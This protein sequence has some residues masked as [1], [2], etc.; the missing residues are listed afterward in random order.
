MAGNSVE[1]MQA[2][3]SQLSQIGLQ[4]C[5]K[6]IIE[7]SKYLIADD[8]VNFAL[9]PLGV[10]NNGILTLIIAGNGSY[11]NR[12]ASWTLF[13]SP[14]T[15]SGTYEQIH[16]WSMSCEEAKKIYFSSFGPQKQLTLG[17]SQSE[18]NPTT[19]VY[20]SS[21]GLDSCTTVKK[22]LLP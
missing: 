13:A 8:K 22:E 18:L 19:H 11:G 12:L 17:I 14:N 3:D 21:N 1:A 16:H 20:F 10:V 15:C 2:L 5:R 4:V 7:L 6:K 9:H